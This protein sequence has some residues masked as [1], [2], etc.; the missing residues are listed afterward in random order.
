MI[1]EENPVEVEADIRQVIAD[2]AARCRGITVDIK[3]LL[4]AIR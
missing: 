3:R 1:P 4:L 2:A